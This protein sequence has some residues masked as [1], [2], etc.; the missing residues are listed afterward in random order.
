MEYKEPEWTAENMNRKQGDT[1][2][3]TCGWCKYATSGSVRYNCM[4]DSYCNL[5]KKYDNNRKVKWD[6]KCLILDYG[7]MDIKSAI[8]SKEYYTRDNQNSIDR[9][10]KEIEVLRSLKLNNVPPMVESRPHDYYNLNDIV[11]VFHDKKWCQGCV[12]NGYRHHDGCVSYVLDDYTE[13]KG[14]WG[15]GYR[16]PCILKEWEYNYFKKNKEEFKNWLKRNDREYNGKKM[17]IDDYYDA[18]ENKK[19]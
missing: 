13:S 3:K 12:V 16:H 14:G 9:L 6:T 7:E 8:E 2:F 19:E 5:M 4:L 17:L 11:Y 18:M 15:C 10:K 1:T